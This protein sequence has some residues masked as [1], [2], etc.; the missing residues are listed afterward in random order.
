MESLSLRELTLT[1]EAQVI[2]LIIGAF[3]F[4][5]R[6]CEYV[7][8]P[9]AGKTTLL[10]LGDI[11][12]RNNKKEQISHQ[13]PDL[14][15]CKYITL[16]FRNQK[17]G[18][19][20]DKRTQQRTSDHFLCP[21]RRW[22]RVVTRVL[23]ANKTP[24]K[25]TPLCAVPSSKKRITSEFTLHFIRA[26]CTTF[27]GRPT[28]GFTPHEI[29]NRS[30]RT[31]AAMALFLNNHSPTQIMILGRWKS[32]AF[33]AYIRPQTMEWTNNMSTHMINIEHFTDLGDSKVIPDQD[34]KNG[35]SIT[36]WKD[37]GIRNLDF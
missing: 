36:M 7:Q 3:F 31:G 32:A 25:S 9:E 11:T 29:G 23:L 37:K 21:V 26:T 13:S 22:A 2:D 28:F 15:N 8:T 16:T 20:N 17:N 24:T 30:V 27:G 35:T 1:Q 18:N 34:S 6:A 12:F 10:S 4:A 33:M 5:L 14:A 19:R